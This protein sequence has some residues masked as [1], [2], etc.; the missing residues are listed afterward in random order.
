MELG[1]WDCQKGCARDYDSGV[2]KRAVQ[3]TMKGVVRKA[4]PG[5]H[6]HKNVKQNLLS[7]C[8]QWNSW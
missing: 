8:R 2:V 5:A 1:K 4:M 3:G 7:N 6:E